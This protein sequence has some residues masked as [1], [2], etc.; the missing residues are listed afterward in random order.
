MADR[1]RSAAAKGKMTQ[2]ARCRTRPA[3]SNVEN[4]T[5]AS[6]QPR[7]IEAHAD[8]RQDGTPPPV[9]TALRE[10]SATA[11]PPPQLPCHGASRG[12]PSLV[13]FLNSAATRRARRS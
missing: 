6:Q 12:Y 10:R 11:C 1:D 7:S 4:P 9:E 5:K 2:K 13:C 8:A 3:A